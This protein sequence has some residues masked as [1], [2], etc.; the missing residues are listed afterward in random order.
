MWK[1]K[2]P[3]PM[4]HDRKTYPFKTDNRIYTIDLLSKRM[5][6]GTNEAGD[7]L[8]QFQRPP[9]IKR[10]DHFEW[11]FALTAI[12]GGLTGVTNEDYLNEAPARGYQPTFAIHMPPSDP[13][14]RAYAEQTF[15]LKSRNGQA[16]GHFHVKIYPESHDGASLE[17]ES[18]V[19]PSGSRNLEF[20]PA[21][22]VK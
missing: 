16:Y 10:R 1:L 18:Y 20:D 9:E 6:E 5:A 12:G 8:V 19:N 17:I 14:W 7:L 4:I 21:K 3:E 13:A 22:Q 11:S 2:G 15:Y